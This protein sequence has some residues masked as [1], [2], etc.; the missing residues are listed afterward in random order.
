MITKRVEP[1][2]GSLDLVTD[3]VVVRQAYSV[4]RS[5]RIRRELLNWFVVIL[6]FVL[7][8]GGSVVVAVLSGWLDVP[9]DVQWADLP[10]KL[11]V[12]G[13][14]LAYVAQIAGAILSFRI[15]IAAGVMSLFVPGYIF[16]CLRRS[17]GIWPVACV[18]LVG[19]AAIGM[20][21]FLLG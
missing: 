19:I 13:F 7:L 3:P 21:V 11:V 15:S 18:W 8:I 12:A 5:K 2:I 9:K 20:G 6:L 16:F 1:T 14:A 17:G 10:A 4:A